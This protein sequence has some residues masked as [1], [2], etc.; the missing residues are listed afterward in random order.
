MLPLT[1]LPKAVQRQIATVAIREYCVHSYLYYEKNTSII[2]DGEYDELCAWLRQNLKALREYD[3]NGYLD[4]EL[5]KA[6]S[7]YGLKLSGQTLEAAE[8]RYKLLM[9]E[10]PSFKKQKSAD[11]ITKKVTTQYKDLDDLF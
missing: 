9:E 7:G 6:G 8:A 10:K 3:L 2:S 11:R 4:K 5:L 1:E